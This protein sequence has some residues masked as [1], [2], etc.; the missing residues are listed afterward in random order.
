MSVNSD[1]ESASVTDD[2]E[3]R[4]GNENVTFFC[5]CVA[6]EDMEELRSS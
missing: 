3:L 2:K 4:R 5:S 1:W 6:T